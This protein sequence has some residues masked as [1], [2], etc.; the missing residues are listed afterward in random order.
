MEDPIDSLL[1]EYFKNGSNKQEKAESCYDI[2]QVEAN[3]TE[4]S[5]QFQKYTKK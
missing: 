1:E 2:G 4:S 5:P 3:S